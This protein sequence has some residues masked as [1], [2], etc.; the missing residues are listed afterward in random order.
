[1]IVKTEILTQPPFFVAGIAVRTINNGQA[2]KD[3]KALWDRF[4]AENILSK[5]DH[6]V[7][8]DIYNVYTDYENDYTGYYTAIL[9]CKVSTL[10]GL[11]DGFTGVTIPADKY[12]VHSLGGKGFHKVIDAWQ[13]IWN[14]ETNRKYTVDFDVYTPNYKSFEDSEVKIF[15][16]IK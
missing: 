14:T 16:G 2:G 6:K 10:V 12:K 3:I 13:E 7:S 11:K 9:G 4:F 15:V 5:I 8:G 1:M